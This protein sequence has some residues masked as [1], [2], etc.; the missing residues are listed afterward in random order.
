MNAFAIRVAA[1]AVLLVTAA[2]VT[3]Q[4]QTTA[5]PAYDPAIETVARQIFN[6]LLSP[7]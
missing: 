1:L 4:G 6:E 7:Y 3:A 2:A 5:R